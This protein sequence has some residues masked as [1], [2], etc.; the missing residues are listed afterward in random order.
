MLKEGLIWRVGNGERID[1]WADPWL[2]R[3]EMRKL[4]TVRGATILQRV[5]E[6]INPTTGTWD[7]EM[8]ND[9]F[10]PEDHD[11]FDPEDADLILKLLVHVQWDDSPA[12]HFDSKGMF[13]VRSAYKVSVEMARREKSSATAS[14]IHIDEAER[15]FWKRMWGLPVPNKVK[16]FVWHLA[17]DTLPLRANLERRGMDIDTRCVMCRRIHEDGAHLFFK[18][19]HVAVVWQL[20]QL[21][22]E[23]QTLAQKQSARGVVDAI[24]QRKEEHCSRLVILLWSWWDERNKVREGEQ[25][26]PVHMLAQG[27]HSY[28]V[29]AL[30]L[31]KKET[32]PKAKVISH[33][34]KPATGTLKVNCDGAHNPRTGS[35]G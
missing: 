18:C 15:R 16:H 20:L 4:I 25:K 31:L 32:S 35:G 23:R 22:P 21:E 34:R 29:K 8:V 17:H 2:P 33:W 10:D 9:I 14:M 7:E 5:S 19:K 30:S 12:W 27:I 26:K 6:L 3:D 13:S 24:M 1:I 11:I 28:V